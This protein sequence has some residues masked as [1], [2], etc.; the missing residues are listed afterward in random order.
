[1]ASHCTD[2]VVPAHNI[3]KRNYIG[4]YVKN[5]LL[6]V[7]MWLK[8]DWLWIHTLQ[9]VPS[10]QSLRQD[11]FIKSTDCICMDFVVGSQETKCNVYITFP[12]LK[13]YLSVLSFLVWAWILKCRST[14]SCGILTSFWYASFV[15]WYVCWLKKPWLCIILSG[16]KE[17]NKAL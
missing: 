11:I 10:S 17:G 5:N 7:C 13:T 6:C 2:W 4:K 15:C 14:S 3:L 8:S 16:R 9:F 12:L 1:M